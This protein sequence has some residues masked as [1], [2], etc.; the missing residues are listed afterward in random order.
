[1]CYHGGAG[2]ADPNE[3]GEAGNAGPEEVVGNGWT[4][5]RRERLAQVKSCAIE[6]FIVHLT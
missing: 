4:R 2:H 5:L 3:V 1:M 6:L